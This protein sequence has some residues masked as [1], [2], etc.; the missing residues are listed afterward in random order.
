MAEIH[1][2]LGKLS[3]LF[4][5]A[6]KETLPILKKAHQLLLE[7]HPDVVIVPRLGE[8]SISYGLGPKKNSEAY[9]YLIA[10]TS[11]V[12][13]GFFHGSRLGADDLLEGTGQLMRHLKI[14]SLEDL[15]NPKI[16]KLIKAAL[17]DRRANF[18]K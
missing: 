7:I 9:C 14:S 4:S 15:K 17:K 2:S 5:A 3:D 6:S 12:N 8:R 11:H 16:G 10:Y 1:E 13:L 18:P